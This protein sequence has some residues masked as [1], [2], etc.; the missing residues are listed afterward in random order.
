MIVLM[1]KALW[2]INIGVQKE[3]EKSLSMIKGLKYQSMNMS[4]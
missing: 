1:C 3:I 4:W 2:L